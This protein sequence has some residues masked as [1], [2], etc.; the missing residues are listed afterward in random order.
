M[1]SGKRK[2]H[3]CQMLSDIKKVLK[4]AAFLRKATFMDLSR[5]KQLAISFFPFFRGYY[6]Q[7]AGRKSTELVKSFQEIRQTVQIIG[8]RKRKQLQCLFFR[9]R[10]FSE[11]LLKRCLKSERCKRLNNMNFYFVQPVRPEKLLVR[12]QRNTNVFIE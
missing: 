5:C 8:K 3:A 10:L 12:T 4:L 6:P 9:E 2:L 1:G 11:I 7:K